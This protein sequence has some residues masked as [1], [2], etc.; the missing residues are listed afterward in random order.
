MNARRVQDP[1]ARSSGGG[2]EASACVGPGQGSG[3][4]PAGERSGGHDPNVAG[5]GRPAPVRLIL[6]WPPSVNTY[7]RAVRGRNIL[8]AKG[9]DYKRA[10]GSAI[11][12]AGFPK[13]RGR[14]GIVLVLHPPDN[15]I[16]DVDN[17]LK[18]VLDALVSEGVIEAD[19]SR[20]LRWI[21]GEWA[22]TESRTNPRVEVTVEPAPLGS[23]AKDRRRD[24]RRH[25]GEA[26]CRMT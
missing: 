2:V 24:P 3:M 21:R 6:P 13:F 4:G 25:E 20:I 15:R 7:W 23:V 18:P 19:D 1:G 14:C 11:A 10:A 17:T 26:R 12:I 22:T 16:R 8:S 9:R 5:P